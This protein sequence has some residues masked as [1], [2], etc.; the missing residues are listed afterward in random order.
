M[1]DGLPWPDESL[2]I[3]DLFPGD[4]VTFSFTDLPKDAR[5]ELRAC[6]R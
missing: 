1:L 3:R 2:T 6:F 5:D 4:T